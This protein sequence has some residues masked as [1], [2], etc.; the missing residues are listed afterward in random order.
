MRK[1]NRQIFIRSLFPL[2]VL[3]LLFWS[4]A[5][6]AQR[7]PLGIGVAEQNINPHSPFAMILFKV[8]AWQIQFELAIQ[9]I[10]ISMRD[11][12]EGALWL[13]SLS[14][15]YGVLHA[16]GPGHGKAV[17]ASYLVADHA[18][19]KRG[20][21]LSFF[22]SILQALSAICIIL[23]IFLFLPG[24]LTQT[25]HFV[26]LLSYALVML[27]GLWLLVRRSRAW[28]VGRKKSLHTLFDNSSLTSPPANS[29]SVVPIKSSSPFSAIGGT[30]DEMTKF[31]ICAE[32]GQSHLIG[33]QHVGQKLKL[34][35]AIPL[36]CATGLRPCNG[37]LFV[38]SFAFLNRLEGVGMLSVFAM[39]LG[40][41]ITVSMLA[42]LAV[43]AKKLSL[44]LTSGKNHASTRL[45]SLI[46]WGAALFIFI[47]G[48]LLLFSSLV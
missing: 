38:M 34:K 43:F 42:S 13:I 24:Q 23:A 35:T 44:K 1:V 41:F 17:I 45:K 12:P 2:L 30:A 26:V 37:A 20:V 47:T 25:T 19:L 46:E 18:S 39:A 5:V 22:S 11:Q 29:L 36:I 40:T 4:K 21:I 33:S 48:A 31:P 27:V 9:K 28:W 8:Q 10:L 15:L 16:A 7:S 6:M 14:F 3:S 32:C